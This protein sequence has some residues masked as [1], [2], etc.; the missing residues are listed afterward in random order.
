MLCCECCVT[1]KGQH[2]P[3]CQHEHSNRSL[4]AQKVDYTNSLVLHRRVRLD[5]QDVLLREQHCS[6]CSFCQSV[7][8]AWL[9]AMPISICGDVAAG[10]QHMELMKSTM[11]G[12]LTSRF[13]TQSRICHKMQWHTWQTWLPSPVNLAAHAPSCLQEQQANTS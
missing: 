5:E 11:P 9:G 7:L 12:R 6:T 1:P 8:Q 13:C 3:A 2:T 10:K 4:C